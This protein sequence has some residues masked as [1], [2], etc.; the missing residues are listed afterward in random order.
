MSSVCRPPEGN[1]HKMWE[2]MVGQRR[3]ESRRRGPRSVRSRARGGDRALGAQ[4][5][6]HAKARSGGSVKCPRNDFCDSLYLSSLC[7]VLGTPKS[8]IVL[9]LILINTK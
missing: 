6:G 2:W 7:C 1:E 8:F 9:H 4:E 5:R 3:A